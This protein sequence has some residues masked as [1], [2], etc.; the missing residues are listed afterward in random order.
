M[1]FTPAIGARKNL[2]SNSLMGPANE[3]PFKKV[4]KIDETK[5]REYFVESGRGWK[6]FSPADI[7]D[8]IKKFSEKGWED[9]VITMTAKLTKE[10]VT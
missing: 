8:K 7:K 2:E 9:N 6:L 3:Q 1:Q 4:S 10:A 5:I